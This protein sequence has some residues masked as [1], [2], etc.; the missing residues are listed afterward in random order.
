MAEP[1]DAA[2]LGESISGAVDHP[3]NILSAKHLARVL[4]GLP[5]AESC[6]VPWA[7]LHARTFDHDVLDCCCC[8]DGRRLLVKAVV[9][10]P[11]EAEAI[12]ASL[13]R[14]KVQQARGPPVDVS[15]GAAQALMR[16]FD[17]EGWNAGRHACP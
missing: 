15:S 7:I 2:A 8:C 5:C 6:A 16:T 12:P 11:E 13:S 14:V 10:D 17:F 3:S 4:G 1:I 9:A